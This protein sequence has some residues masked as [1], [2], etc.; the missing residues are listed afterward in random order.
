[1]GYS[2]GV[3]LGTSSVRAAVTTASGAEMIALAGRSAVLPS[4][5]ALG[6][7]GELL[8]GEAAAARALDSPDRVVGG[9]KRHLGAPNPVMLGGEAFSVIQL[10]AA[11]LGEVVTRVAETHGEPP[12]HVAL[13]HPVN[14]GPF[15]RAQFEELPKLAGLSSALF[16][17]EAEATALH[18][19]ATRGVDDGDAV[20][21][22]DLGGAHVEASVLRKRSSG[23]EI[24]GET[25]GVELGG[26][27][28]D[29]AIL[30]FVDTHL[31]GA[32]GDLDS[33]SPEGATALARLRQECV[34]AKEALSD[35]TETTI[36]VFLPGRYDDVPLTRADFEHL[37]LGTVESAVAELARS[38]SSAQLASGNLSAVLVVGGSSHIP[39]VKRLV[40]QVAGRSP[41]PNVHP[42]HS[43]ALGA[44]VAA[45]AR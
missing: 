35:E 16:L 45:S 31:G 4:V 23:F 11:L 7:D 38:V 22:C 3:D 37:I 44:A 42:E 41:V 25:A 39:L 24:V 28:F 33:D 5:V 2:I 13:T 18:F 40:A 32:V 10:L 1:M 27:D 30:D 29:R 12:E 34:L 26:L 17:S 15:R 20:A 9:F 14:W 8:V 6:E 21:I 43:V 19:A 36:P